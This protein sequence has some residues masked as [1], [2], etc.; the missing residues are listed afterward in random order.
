MYREVVE[1]LSNYKKSY[2]W[3]YGNPAMVIRL[4]VTELKKDLDLVP[5][6]PFWGK[7]EEGTVWFSVCGTPVGDWADGSYDD[8]L[9]ICGEFSFSSFRSWSTHPNFLHTSLSLT[10]KEIFK[11]I[12]LVVH[13]W[14]E[15]NFYL[16]F[17]RKETS[18]FKRRF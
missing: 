11:K 3:W 2:F 12:V 9:F 5:P 8:V 7:R 17:E 6:R 16:H 13:T 15:R 1:T 10:Q 4:G 18:N 14:D